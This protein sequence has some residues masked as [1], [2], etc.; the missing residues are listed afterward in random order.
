MVRI[1][2]LQIADDVGLDDGV[3][4]AGRGGVGTNT[5]QRFHIPGGNVATKG[6]HQCLAASPGFLH[7]IAA[8]ATGHTQPGREFLGGVHLPPGFWSKIAQDTQQIG[9]GHKA[10]GESSVVGLDFLEQRLFHLAA[11]FFRGDVHR[12]FQRLARLGAGAITGP[13]LRMQIFQGLRQAPVAAHH[14][15]AGLAVDAGCRIEEFFVDRLP[16]SGGDGGIMLGLVGFAQHRRRAAEDIG[17]P[18]M[19]GRIDQGGRGFFDR[20]PIPQ[21]PLL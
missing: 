8:A 9:R 4:E 7:D 6:R 14:L 2:P 20:Q 15:P 5:R 11:H 16:Q 17:K 12:Q 13:P 10:G 21:A 1:H 19:G 18:D 3:F